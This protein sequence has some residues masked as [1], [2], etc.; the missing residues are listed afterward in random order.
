VAQLGKKTGKRF[1]K[2]A[3][4]VDFEKSYALGEACEVIAKTASAK[5]DE[6]VEVVVCLGVDPR[7]ADQNVRGTTAL[8]HGLGKNV[9][10]AVFAKGE[11]AKEAEAAGA[12]IVGADDLAEK[13]K[14]GFFDF[15]TVVATPDMMGQVGKV[16]KL[17]GPRGLMPSP[18]VGTVTFDV[19]ATVKSIKA[20]RA[21]FRVDKAG[22]VHSAVGKASFGK[23]KILENATALISALNR[24]KPQTSKGVY[25][26]SAA[27]SLTMGPG[28]RLD[29]SSIRNV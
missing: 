25:I 24:A 8:P 3:A 17:L 21:E 14:G 28:V 20:G 7:K 6:T 4:L 15:D 12:D 26:K 18:K 13:I 22:L 1:K 19:T 5:F 29:P 27:M 16:G 2:V 11:K 23:D 9:R 10:V